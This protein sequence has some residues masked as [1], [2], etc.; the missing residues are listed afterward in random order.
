M[1][2]VPREMVHVLFVTGQSHF[3]P[4]PVSLT[5][6]FL[7]DLYPKGY[8]YSSLNTARSAISALYCADKTELG[9]NIGK[10]PLTLDEKMD[11]RG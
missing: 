1:Q 3:M 9:Q 10:Q 5:L 2:C 8:S 6:D 11:L 4:T 7:H